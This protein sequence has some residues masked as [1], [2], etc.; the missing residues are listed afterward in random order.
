MRRALTPLFLA[1]PSR[2]ATVSQPTARA[3]VALLALL[4]A[5]T[6][7][8]V[9]P[10]GQSDTGLYGAIVEGVRHGGNYYA[11]TADALR[12]GNY[13]LMPF[14]AFRLPTLAVIEAALPQFAV[15]AMLDLL[16][17]VVGVAWYR[18]LRPV[19]TL[20]G[21]RTLVALLL[22]AGLAATLRPP[23]APLADLWAGLAIALSL[24]MRRRGA[25]VDAI[26][27]GLAAAVLRETAA[28]YIVVMAAFAL[29]ERQR[30]ELLG[31]GLA[32]VIVAI[33]LVVHAGAVA[34]VVK[35]LDTADVDW[36]GFIGV[37]AFVSASAAAVLPAW[38]PLSIGAP[39][40]LLSVFGW[41]SWRDPVA[42]RALAT[43]AAVALLVAIF[44]RDDTPDWAL[45]VT[46]ILL[47]GLVF[48]PDA[49]RDI[50]RAALDSR[51][52][53]VTRIIR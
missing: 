43:I 50:V 13:P 41:A 51:R 21:A 53:T 12:A 17:A 37:G 28:L 19:L 42:A 4:L 22:I 2:F 44:G 14:T 20:R 11:V 30:R 3:V 24:A 25:I 15:L 49:L 48:V 5:V 31:W 36:T 10:P 47:T 27:L 8:G 26:A 7:A 1:A 45:L 6:I 23:L 40:V 35:P 46:P 33:V 39:I 52:I 16:T 32:L 38:L 34:E 29:V 18:R 9:A